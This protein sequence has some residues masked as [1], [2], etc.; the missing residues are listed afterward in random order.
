MKYAPLSGEGK[1]RSQSSRMCALAEKG[2]FFALREAC[3]VKRRKHYYEKAAAGRRSNLHFH[4]GNFDLA[5]DGFAHRSDDSVC[6]FLGSMYKEG[7]GVE[8][9]LE[10]A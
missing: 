10:I 2:D 3:V 4:R 6:F 9:D 7:C 1:Y 5:L 8:K